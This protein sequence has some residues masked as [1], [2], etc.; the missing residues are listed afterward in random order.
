MICESTEWMA[1]FERWKNHAALDPNAVR[2]L[3]DS[4]LAG[5]YHCP[6]RD[7][8]AAGTIKNLSDQIA[9]LRM[10][11]CA[12]VED[13]ENQDVGGA[14]RMLRLALDRTDR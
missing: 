9:Y 8:E 14:C 12:S 5:T 10:V 6:A 2:M 1:A 3:I 11:M 13:I 4:L 7:I